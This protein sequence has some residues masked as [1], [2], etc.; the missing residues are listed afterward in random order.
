MTTVT[1]EFKCPSCGSLNNRASD[2]FAAD[3]PSPGDASICFYCF[4]LMIFGEGLVVRQ[5]TEAERAELESDPEFKALIAFT[6]MTRE[7][8]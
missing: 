7:L 8:H 4:N 5:P 1:P 6:K 3:K 2:A